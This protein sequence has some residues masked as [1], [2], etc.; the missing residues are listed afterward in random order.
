MIKFIYNLFTMNRINNEFKIKIDKILKKEKDFLNLLLVS[1]D[2]KNIYTDW[3]KYFIF[4]FFVD[5]VLLTDSF[6]VSVKNRSYH[7]DKIVTRILIERFIVFQYVVRGRNQN[8]FN[9][10]FLQSYKE[11]KKFLCRVLGALN[12]SIEEIPKAINKKEVK[13]R[14]N[15]IDREIKKI[16]AQIKNIKKFDMDDLVI[17]NKNLPYYL[18]VVSYPLLSG[19]VHG[20]F[21]SLEYILESG[22][23][24]PPLIKIIGNIPSNQRGRG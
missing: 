8:R 24:K 2:V 20:N 16:E 18:R 5:L 23:D 7:V 19:Y 15:F 9:N 12:N 4:L 17:K 14:I 6:L 3:K 10:L 22:K 13:D 11:D 21:R 1:D